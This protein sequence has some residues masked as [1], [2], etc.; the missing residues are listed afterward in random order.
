MEVLIDYL[1]TAPN[2]ILNATNWQR[3]ALPDCTSTVSTSLCLLRDAVST[4][5]AICLNELRVKRMAEEPVVA[6]SEV[7]LLHFFFIGTEW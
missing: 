5:E 7:P 2:S 4:E 1:Y 6:Y 3:K